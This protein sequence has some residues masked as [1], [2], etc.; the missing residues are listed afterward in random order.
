M[1]DVEKRKIWYAKEYESC[2]FHKV[3][4]IGERCFWTLLISGNFYA[5]G[6]FYVPYDDI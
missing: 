5:L 6:K 2:D 3:Y 1:A 4:I